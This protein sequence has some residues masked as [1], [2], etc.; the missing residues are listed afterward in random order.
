MAS[1]FSC[2]HA[3]SCR[4]PSTLPPTSTILL[5][6]LPPLEAKP[7]R[8]VCKLGGIRAELNPSLVINLSLFLGK[9]GGFQHGNV[10][11]QGLLELNSSLVFYLDKVEQK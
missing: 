3:C 7:A 9:F 10:V 4:R 5:P 8:S 2:A 11:K 1:I 6:L